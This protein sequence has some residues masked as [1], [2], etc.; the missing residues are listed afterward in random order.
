[1]YYYRPS[2]G[3]ARTDLATPALPV[4]VERALW[5]AVPL[6][7][8]LWT[9]GRAS[10]VWYS[11]DVWLM[12]DQT[13]DG[14]DGLLSGHNGQLLALDFLVYRIQMSVFGLESTVVVTAVFCASLVALHVS[15]ALLAH[16]IGTSVVLALAIGGAIT[17]I[18]PGVE[19]AVNPFSLGHNTGLALCFFAGWA[20]LGHPQSAS[21]A[22]TISL[23]LVVAVLTSSSLGGIGVL[24]VGVITVMCWPVRS[25]ALMLAPATA[26]VMIWAFWGTGARLV[27][28][29]DSTMAEF[30]WRLVLRAA[31]GLSGLSGRADA[32]G[33]SADEAGIPSLILFAA[34][35]GVAVSSR[36]LDRSDLAVTLGG[37]LAA[38]ATV[39]VLATQRG[40]ASLL[41]KP[42]ALI[43]TRYVHW[44]ALFG[45]VALLPCVVALLR[46]LSPPGRKV[47]EVGLAVLFVV[48][49]NVGAVRSEQRFFE[50]W[51]ESN[52]RFSAES[53][54]VVYEG[55]GT[56]GAVDPLAAAPS[57]PFLTIELLARLVD[58]GLLHRS[59]G[60]E[61]TPATL[62]ELCFNPLS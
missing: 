58:A 14:F 15:I 31:S 33:L 57:D 22:R 39:V 59:F 50:A 24:F 36:R 46:S 40:S 25:A 2:V 42:V 4:A 56:G 1:M 9:V 19:N 62:D 30:A 16:R 21:R 52:R 45:L 47:A 29:S 60:E 34:V 37:V 38:G 41:G 8:L 35:V 3:G 32:L 54:T 51:G 10:R 5:I 6:A 61:P 55:C 23:L 28:P 12:L 49:G 44:V 11:L 7:G 17:Y 53:V 26:L 48:S 13:F 27:E 43:Q 20:A 18:G